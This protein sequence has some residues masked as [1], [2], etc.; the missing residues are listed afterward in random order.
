[1]ARPRVDAYDAV[2]VAYLWR[3]YTHL[4]S[5]AECRAHGA[6]FGERRIAAH[7]ATGGEATDEYA[8]HIRQMCGSIEA[9]ETKALLADG[10]D[11]FYRRA[12]ERILRDHGASIVINRCPACGSIVVSPGARQCLWCHYD[13]HGSA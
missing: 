6:L 10:V 5:L 11:A 12:C 2:L 4:F 8:T 7:C 3:N 1:M 9:P 13:W